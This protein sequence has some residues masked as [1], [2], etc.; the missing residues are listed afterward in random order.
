VSLE[1]SV[2]SV[3]ILLFVFNGFRT[4]DGIGAV[5]GN[6]EL[7]IGVFFFSSGDERAACG[8]VSCSHCFLFCYFFLKKKNLIRTTANFPDILVPQYNTSSASILFYFAFYAI[9]LFFL[10]PYIL[11][12]LFDSFKSV[13]KKEARRFA[14]CRSDMLRCVFYILDVEKNGKLGS[15]LVMRFLEQVRKIWA[16]KRMSKDK[17]VELACF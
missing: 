17:Q 16:F 2:S 1:L 7:R 12:L 15:E 10:L 8:I 13:L 9:C 14:V 5:A 4:V 3:I 6:S 11:A